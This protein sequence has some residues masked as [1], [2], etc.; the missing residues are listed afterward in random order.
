MVER[1]LKAGADADG[2]AATG[3]TAIMLAARAGSPGVVKTLVAHGAD[4]NAKTRFG[5]TALMFAA[6]ERHPDVVRAAG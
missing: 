6:A 2:R 5:D 1:L 4:V 3:E